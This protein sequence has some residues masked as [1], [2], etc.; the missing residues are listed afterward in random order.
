MSE[1]KAW[2]RPVAASADGQTE[3][4]RGDECPALRLYEAAD[5]QTT[6]RGDECGVAHAYTVCPYTVRTYCRES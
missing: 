2:R 5:D 6:V 1:H 3:T 4:V